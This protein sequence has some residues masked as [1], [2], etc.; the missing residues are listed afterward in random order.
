MIY[1]NSLVAFQLADGTNNEFLITEPTTAARNY[2]MCKTK[3]DLLER[4]FIKGGTIKAKQLADLRIEYGPGI[5]QII[6]GKVDK[7]QNCVD[8]SELVLTTGNSFVA[9]RSAQKAYFDPRRPN[10]HWTRLGND[11]SFKDSTE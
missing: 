9:A 4:H 10:A 5:V 1:E 2:A 8:K 7:L 11:G 6:Q 3:L